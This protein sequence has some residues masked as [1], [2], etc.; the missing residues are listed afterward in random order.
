[1][2][3][4]FFS[5]IF[6][7]Q[8][9]QA[10]LYV[11]DNTYMYVKDTYVTVT[12]EVELDGTAS[13]IYLRNDGQLLQKGTTPANAGTGSLSVFQEGSVNQY[14]FNY[15]CSPVGNPAGSAG[16]SPFGITLLNRPTTSI[17][18]SNVSIIGSYNGF[19]TNSS[20]VIS[21]YW[22]Y[23]FLSSSNYSQWSQVLDATS[24]NAGEGFTMKGTSGSDTT[25][26]F[27]G[28]GQNKPNPDHDSNPVTPEIHI[29]RYDFRGRPNDGEITINL[30]TDNYTLTGN[31]YPSAINLR[32]FLVGDSGLGIPG[33][34]NCTG[35]AYFWEH[36]KTINSH[37]LTA[38][39]GGYGTYAGG[40]GVYTA[41]SFYAYD[42]AGTQLPGATGTGTSIERLFSPIGQGF[43][44][45][46]NSSGSTATMRNIY[47]VYRKEGNTYNSEFERSANAINSSSNPSD[48]ANSLIPN[49]ADVSFYEANTAVSPHIKI[50]TLLNNQGVKPS[51][52]VF[53]PLATD[54]LDQ[55]MDAKSTTSS[56]AVD[57]FYAIEGKELVQAAI[58]FS[59]EK[60]IPV[61]F[62][63]NATTPF[64]MQV[65]EFVNFD[66]ATNVF[67]FDGL[68]QMYHD[69]K[70][71]PYA[72]ELPQ[73][74]HLNRFEIT[75]TNQ[76]LSNPS[77][78]NEDVFVVFQEQQNQLVLQNS[79]NLDI[80]TV[81]LYDLNGRLLGQFENENDNYTFNTSKLQDAVYVALIKSKSQVN[82]SQ[83]V[84]VK[85]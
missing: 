76:P 1:M 77:F 60:R 9:C 19:T 68:T 45:E 12:D 3:Y 38:Y 17:N 51:A 58:N 11:S 55:G 26:P 84:I 6:L 2:K 50:N 64:K 75:F 7:V 13:N 10:Q 23:K 5:I 46:G 66:S 41:A 22:I 52:I 32:W 21:K 43:M 48:E 61:G 53:H 79:K 30:A 29:Q 37:N 14:Q 83:K 81:E 35:I 54:F 73:G 57:M 33:N 28:V 31:P 62:E 20:L 36:D 18:S 49:V 34:P 70:T 65:D 80:K 16:N 71:Q 72:F 69:I 40:T 24:I 63:C 56:T 78:T 42:G 39:R 4:Y 74:T 15:W 27:T 8:I 85:N 44:I 59:I 67:L 47:R 82:I 25:E